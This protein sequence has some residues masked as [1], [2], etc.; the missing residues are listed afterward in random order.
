MSR[1][2]G[3][4]LVELLVALALM[5]VVAGLAFGT[6]RTGA[7]VWERAPQAAPPA[8]LAERLRGLIGEA[9]TAPQP[10]AGLARAVPFLGE[11]AGLRFLRAGPE[12]LS[13][14]RLA[15][16]GDRLVVWQRRVARP[17]ELLEPLDW[18]E[19]FADLPGIGPASFAYADAGGWRADWPPGPRPPLL[20]RLTLDGA[21][22]VAIVIAPGARR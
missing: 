11:A 6:L 1:D 2:A 19:P 12:G 9:L 22:P 16:A 14:W 15:L 18:G 10:R 20:V 8:L 13:A 4:S 5:A 21:R 7:R 17:A 3:F